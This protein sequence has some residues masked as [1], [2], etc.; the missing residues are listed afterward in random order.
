MPIIFTSGGSEANNL[1]LKGAAA[2]FKP[3]RLAVGAIEHPCVREPARQLQRSGWQRQEIP[4]DR[5]GRIDVEAFR[6]LLAERP[7]L[8]SVML[9]NNETGVLQD[10]PALAAEVRA[11]G[12]WMR[13]DAVQAL[14]KVK[15]RFRRPRACRTDVCRPHKIWPAG[16]RRAGGE[17]AGRAR[18]AGGRGRAGAQPA[19]RHR[20]R[21]GHR[22]LRQGL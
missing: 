17:Q 13:S 21:D 16:R 4:V 2:R 5:Q 19:F 22:R 3:G 20:E 14:G 11:A 10:I 15:L 8:V 18:P 1:F 9:A 7:S 12:G 6:W